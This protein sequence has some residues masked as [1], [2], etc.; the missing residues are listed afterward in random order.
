MNNTTNNTKVIGIILAYKHARFLEG[1]YR[2]IPPGVF[3]EIIITND[4]TGDGIEQIAARLGIPCFSHPRLGYGGNLKYGLKKGLERGGDYL[5]EIHGDGQF[6]VDI[7]PAA[8]AK[9]REGYDFVSGSRFVDIRQPL[10]DK[11]PLV[12]Y[13]A[14]ITLSFFVRLVTGVKL[15]DCHN[16]YRVYSR[17][18]LT[19]ID[20]D[21]TAD[22]FLFAFE[23]VAL[24]KLAG[25]K[26]AEVPIR[27]FYGQDH[28]S[29]SIR[30]SIAFAFQEAKSMLKYLLARL[31][32]RLRPYR[33]TAI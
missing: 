3:D 1:L 25:V 18:L 13:V 19:S 20:L 23:I 15:S 21:Q 8:I 17:K 6:D 24:A 33:R 27:C 11:M 10:R 29:I 14:N 7:S 2:S 30:R 5:V 32:I 9:A 4:E 22:D 26:I 31:G 16:G 28:S 12:R